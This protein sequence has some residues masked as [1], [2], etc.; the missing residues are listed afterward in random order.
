MTHKKGLQFS[1]RQPIEAR[2]AGTPP[3]SN[4][5]RFG[6]VA[7]LG[8]RVNGIHEVVG[9]NPIRSTVLYQL[10]WYRGLPRP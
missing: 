4:P 1:S 6:A 10:G 7:Q 2:A 5:N 3:P 9:S 8:E